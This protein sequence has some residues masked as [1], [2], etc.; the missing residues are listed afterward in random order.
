MGVLTPRVYRSADIAL[1]AAY[2]LAADFQ[3]SVIETPET[4]ATVFKNRL[5]E[6]GQHLDRDHLD[7]A[8]RLV[9]SIQARLA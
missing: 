2:S 8:R 9:A 5:R 4:A 1:V 3:L 7:L 6:I